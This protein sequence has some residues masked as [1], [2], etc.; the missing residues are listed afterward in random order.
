MKV[1]RE[2]KI[3]KLLKSANNYVTLDSIIKRDI[4]DK[5]AL[6]KKGPI[7]T[8]DGIEDFFEDI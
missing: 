4:K 3:L 8:L 7:Y 6:I 5:E 1:E 2:N